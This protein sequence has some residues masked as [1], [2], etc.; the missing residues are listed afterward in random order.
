MFLE[1]DGGGLGMP[2]E[3]FTIG[4]RHGSDKSVNVSHGDTSSVL[5]SAI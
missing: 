5:T 3:L 1:H 2:P 4:R